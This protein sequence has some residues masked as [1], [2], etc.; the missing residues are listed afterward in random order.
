MVAPL[1]DRYLEA[2]LKVDELEYD[3]IE[4]TYLF[5]RNGRALTSSQWSQ[6]VKQ[7]FGRHSPNGQSPPPKGEAR[8]LPYTF[9]LTD[10]F[11]LCCL[12]LSQS[13][14]NPAYIVLRASFITHLRSSDAAPEV[15]KSAARAQRHQEETQASDLYDVKVHMRLV[16][17]SVRGWRCQHDTAR[18]SPPPPLS[19]VFTTCSSTGVSPMR[20]RWR[21][22]V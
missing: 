15:L 18:P 5:Q 2:R 20:A 12:P 4:S 3:S 19:L 8:L 1:I 7:A 14:P 13:I 17:A 22:T 21:R 9:K 10:T 11:E 16:K 6:F